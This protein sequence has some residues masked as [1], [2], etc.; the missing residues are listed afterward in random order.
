[1]VRYYG[2]Y[3]SVSRGKRKRQN[4]DES[5]PY[6]LE[7]EQSFPVMHLELMPGKAVQENR[8]FGVDSISRE[9]LKKSAIPMAKPS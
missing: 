1:M 8:L 6:I 5:I 7:S 4:K 2:Y 9:C 3:S